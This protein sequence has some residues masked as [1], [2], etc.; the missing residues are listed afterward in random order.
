MKRLKIRNVTPGTNKQNSNRYCG[1]AVIS[2]LTGMTTGE[3]AKLIR[4][5]SNRQRVRGTCTW[6]IIASLRLCRIRVADRYFYSSDCRRP[7]VAKWLKDTV[8]IRDAKRVFLL[9]AGYHWLLVQGRRYVCGRT[10]E[11]VSI[12]DPKVKRRARVR[13]VWECHAS[14]QGYK[15]PEEA[16]LVA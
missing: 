10:K 13:E 7:T 11:I 2:S 1:P 3:A 5:V 16:R 14:P 15:I 4:H 6:E 9:A 8:K 12:R